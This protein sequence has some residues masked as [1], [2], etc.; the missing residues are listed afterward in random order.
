MNIFTFDTA[1]PGK[2]ETTLLIKLGSKPI[3]GSVLALELS[4]KLKDKQL[5]DTSFTAS[6]RIKPKT[7][8]LSVDGQNLTTIIDDPLIQCLAWCGVKKVAGHI[9]DC[10]K[11]GHRTPQELLDCLVLKGISI[12][13]DVLK[14]A[15][16]CE[17]N[18]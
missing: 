14:C 18:H 8:Q 3:I 2:R 16:D 12:G 13:S 11:D 5:A 9:W 10:L 15:Q 17:K 1:H 7:S 4:Y 6:F